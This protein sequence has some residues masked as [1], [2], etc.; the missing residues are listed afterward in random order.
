[1]TFFVVNSWAETYTWNSAISGDIKVTENWSDGKTPFSNSYT[2]TGVG[3]IVIG[4]GSA[5]ATGTVKIQGD[6]TKFTLD[7]G[8][9]TVGT[10]GTGT[11]LYT[12][13]K[14]EYLQNS[15]NTTIYGRTYIG[16]DGT[17]HS[18]SVLTI[19]D[20]AFSAANGVSF[21]IGTINVN[22][23]TLISGTSN[24][25]T[26]MAF[27]Q[28]S[29]ILNID[30]GTVKIQGGNGTP[31]KFNAA[32][33]INLKSG[34]LEMSGK[35]DGRNNGNINITG[36]T[37]SGTNLTLDSVKKLDILGNGILSATNLKISGTSKVTISGGSVTENSGY[38]FVTTNNAKNSGLFLTSGTF[39]N[40]ASGIN[41]NHGGYVSV[42]GGEMNL[43]LNLNV[44]ND[45]KGTIDISGGTVKSQYVRV[46]NNSGASGTLN[47]S[48][49][50]LI[51]DGAT[52]NS[53]GLVIGNEGTGILN[54][55]GGSIQ[56]NTN[57]LIVGNKS[58]AHG[59]L[60]L[61]GGEVEVGGTFYVGNAGTGAM[62]VYVD[63]NLTTGQVK[64]TNFT[65]NGTITINSSTTPFM[66]LNTDADGVCKY[67][68]WTG[69][70][71]GS[72]MVT[73]AS[74]MLKVVNG[75]TYY[76]FSFNDALNKDA[77]NI[78]DSPLT[79]I[80]AQSGNVWMTPN[81]NL[82]QLELTLEG[83]DDWDLF[84]DWLEPMTEYDVT[85]SED[86]TLVLGILENSNALNQ[87]FGWDFRGYTGSDVMVTGIWGQGVPE[88]STWLLLML[89]SV[90]LY[91]GHRRG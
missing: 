65:H 67:I 70:K 86:S 22:G 90:G 45:G 80:S 73:S 84:L 29:S 7:G 40:T 17:S 28:T 83:V 38:V 21:Q 78:F 16:T 71:T 30:G 49:G 23:G 6:G 31:I 47:I 79:G 91:F 25:A 60:N 42:S 9:F 77:S 87:Q 59:M 68:E 52:S 72:G 36:G 14:A 3:A 19:N 1:M 39:T 43:K 76:G 51:L 8:N 64:T 18:A 35:V 88:P 50:T 33:S 12:Y 74:D 37:F 75:D 57:N 54:L 89:G 69:T 46:G 61:Y 11:H 44:A 82:Y 27:N 10:S 26:E 62:N 32:G 4:S 5:T 20:G 58:N 24:G 55:S 66:F 48:G 81:S 15:G 34:K 63:E 41:I 85:K 13:G 2:N 53:D 56:T